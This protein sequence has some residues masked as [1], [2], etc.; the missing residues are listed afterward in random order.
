[1]KI[2]KFDRNLKKAI[3]LKPVTMKFEDARIDEIPVV[4]VEK[5]TKTIDVNE[6]YK[7]Q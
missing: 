1:M 6:W 7:Y 3:I 4:R 2:N 5:V